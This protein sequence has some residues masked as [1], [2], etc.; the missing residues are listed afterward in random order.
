VLTWEWA[1]RFAPLTGTG[2]TEV[3]G[4]LTANT[5]IYSITTTLPTAAACS[6][7]FW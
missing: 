3:L 2:T 7:H 5:L 4:G 1:T 6:A